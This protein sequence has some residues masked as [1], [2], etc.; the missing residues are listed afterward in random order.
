[1]MSSNPIVFASAKR[2][3]HFRFSQLDFFDRNLLPRFC[4]PKFMKDGICE[5]DTTRENC[6][7]LWNER[8][9]SIVEVKEQEHEYLDFAFSFVAPKTWCV[10]TQDCAENSICLQVF[11]SALSDKTSE[12]ECS[13]NICA[14]AYPYKV[15]CGDTNKLILNFL[16]NF[17]S[18]DRNYKFLK[19]TGSNYERVAQDDSTYFDA[20]LHSKKFLLT[21]A[22]GFIE[23][24]SR[25]D[26]VV[27]SCR[28]EL[29]PHG[30]PLADV[31]H[32]NICAFY[33]PNKR[34]HYIN[35]TS[36]KKLLRTDFGA[37]LNAIPQNFKCLSQ[38]F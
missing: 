13:F 30:S 28:I 34:Y 24:A 22:K 9:L 26:M 25:N 32:T 6:S 37:M 36:R 7:S 1:M 18:I 14:F 12:M 20:R 15:I 31:Q 3:A 5:G 8:A 16:S 10:L 17:L 27:S 35:F 33:H 38:N 21:T 29:L 4:R 23:S 19:L 11:P 2:F